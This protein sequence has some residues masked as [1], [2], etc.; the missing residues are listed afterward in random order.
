MAREPIILLISGGG[1]L[2]DTLRQRYVEGY[3][4]MVAAHASRS[5]H[6]AARAA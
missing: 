5:A 1:L 6:G 4:I 3:R 2:E